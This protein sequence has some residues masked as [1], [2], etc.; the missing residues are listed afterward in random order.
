MI[1]RHLLAYFRSKPKTSFQREQLVGILIPQVH[2]EEAILPIHSEAFFASYIAFLEEKLKEVYGQNVREKSVERGS[3]GRLQYSF[4]APHI[5]ICYV[6]NPL[7]TP[8]DMK[9]FPFGSSTYHGSLSLIQSPLD[10][11]SAGSLYG[12][13]LADEVKGHG[14][15]L[16]LDS[17]EADLGVY[18][19]VSGVRISMGKNLLQ[20]MGVSVEKGLRYEKSKDPAHWAYSFEC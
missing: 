5:D 4:S 17:D 3:Q 14:F 15:H 16:G 13:L 19:E 18:H 6:A 2:A 9:D 10:F 8:P 20:R 11:R 1:P 12:K 7:Y